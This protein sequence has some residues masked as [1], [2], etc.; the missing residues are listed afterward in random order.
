M[1][2][3]AKSGLGVETVLNNIIDGLPPP[4][5]EGDNKL[6]ALVFD[7]F[8]DRFRGVVSLVR[9]KSGE[10]KKGDKVRFLQAGKKYEV[11][12][13]GIYNPEEV[14]VGS[15]KEGQVGYLICNMKNSEEGELGGLLRADSSSHWRHRVS[16]QRADGA[17]AGL[18]ADE[19]D[20]EL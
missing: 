6:R 12:E 11:L 14:V 7:T 19:G 5:W 17:T 18:P 1:P 20:G 9:I 15:L 8:Y 10:V 3:S 2:I 13:V 16:R 4:T